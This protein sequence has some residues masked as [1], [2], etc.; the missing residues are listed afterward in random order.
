MF[1]RRRGTRGRSLSDASF[2]E[3]GHLRARDLRLE[4]CTFDNC[5]ARGG[6]AERVDLIDCATWACSLH[7]VVLRD[8]SVTNLRTTIESGGG[9]RT[10][11]FLWGVMAQ[12]VTLAGKIGSII[13]NPPHDAW[14]WTS[15]DFVA[16]M[17]FYDAVDD[18]ALDVS[19]ARFTSVPALRFGPPGR[20]V[21][22]D[23]ATQPLV[24]R[25]AAETALSRAASDIGVWRVV[26]DDLLSKPWPDE[27]V[28]V[29]ALGAPKASR[30]D[31]LRRLERLGS[32]GAFEDD[33]LGG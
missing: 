2:H 28:L 15:S 16:A 23:P 26:L 21:R 7:D 6:V 33:D 8:C 29:P 12:R 17:R 22:R 9:R 14:P 11:L 30:E 32:A 13:W 24:S 20:L 10:P 19:A 18:W 25:R 3:S 5:H 27:I 31:D 1:G 4:R